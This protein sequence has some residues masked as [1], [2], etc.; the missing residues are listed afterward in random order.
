M[1]LQDELDIVVG[2]KLDHSSKSD[3][4]ELTLRCRTEVLQ[5]W[6]I[7]CIHQLIR[8]KSNIMHLVVH[9][10][11]SINVS[12]QLM[13]TL[14]TEILKRTSI[15]HPPAQVSFF[16]SSIMEK[17]VT[18]EATQPFG[19]AKENLGNEIK[20]QSTKDQLRFRCH[21]N[22]TRHCSISHKKF[23]LK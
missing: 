20:S 21:N 15:L 3:G 9:I 18:G 6:L 23:N 13:L 7:V 16:E 4:V 2:L 1:T 14:V 8:T 12:I 11:F 22:Q 19:I 17:D 5:T 10:S